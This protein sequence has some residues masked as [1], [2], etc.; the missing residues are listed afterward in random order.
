[1]VDN[2]LEMEGESTLIV[3]RGRTGKT[4]LGI[5]KVEKIKT[6]LKIFLVPRITHPEFHPSK[7]IYEYYEDPI[8]SADELEEAVE[9]SD[10]GLIVFITKKVKDQPSIWEILRDE[11][12]RNFVIC[13]DELAVLVSDAQDKEEFKVFIRHVG[14]NN[15]KFIGITHRIIDDIPPVTALNVQT[16][17]FVGRL[18]NKKEQQNLYDVSNVDDEMDFDQFC[19]KLR[20]QPKKYPWWEK[21]PSEDALFLIYH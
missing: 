14:Q 7:T 5:D 19:E 16:I 13:A 4:G 20:K 6:D 11:R 9:K 1:M 3:G 17:I 10:K 18:A 21:N 2:P 15:Q 12:F 8:M